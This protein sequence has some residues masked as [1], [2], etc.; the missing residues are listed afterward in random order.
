MSFFQ[1]LFTIGESNVHSAIDKL[2]DP[3]KMTEQGIRDLKKDFSSAMTGLAEVKGIAIRTRKKANQTKQLASD[4]ERKA[5]LLLQ[6]MQKNQ[7]DPAEAERLATEA[8]NKK[9]EHAKDADRLNSEAVAHEKRSASLQ[10]RVNKLKSTITSYEN[11]IITLKA[12]ARTA[13]S[14]KKINAQL[15]QIDSSS[16]ITMLEKINPKPNNS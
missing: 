10:S 13:E 16:T 15:A 7:I 6:K 3:I 14:T 5:M 1:R 12:R 11:D 9:E 2:E 4:Y 8:L